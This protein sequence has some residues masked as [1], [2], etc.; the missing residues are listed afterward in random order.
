[1]TASDAGARGSCPVSAP[2]TRQLA[3]IEGGGF[4][5]AT[6]LDAA[7]RPVLL[8]AAEDGHE[9][10]A[11]RLSRSSARLPCTLASG[12]ACAPVLKMAA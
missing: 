4:L 8:A 6:D 11:A 9:Y 1:L 10:L 3:L 5:A 12:A 7:Q 2:I